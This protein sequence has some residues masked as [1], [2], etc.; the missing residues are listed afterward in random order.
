M[1]THFSKSEIQPL[2]K[3]DWR[4]RLKEERRRLSPHLRV[5][6][7]QQ[8]SA[9]LAALPQL[10]S[11]QTI[12]TFWPIEKQH[13]PDIKPLLL[14]WLTEG[15]SLVLP[16]VD[17]STAQQP[18]L[19][20]REAQSESDLI[21]NKWGIAEPVHGPIAN[22]EAIEVVLVP[23]LGIDHTGNRIGYGKG[24]YDRFLTR[25]QCDKIAVA[26]AQGFVAA[27]PAEKHDISVDGV[28]TEAGYHPLPMQPLR[29]EDR[30]SK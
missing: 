19:K 27:L 25:M 24:F 28:V 22:L 23:A 8:I 5:A 18:A 14:S 30:S 26:F 20:H 12:H 4:T 15:K 21:L 3:K 13:E 17:L 7:S 11:A 29:P 9:H 1:P 2:S 10:R 16:V 6:K